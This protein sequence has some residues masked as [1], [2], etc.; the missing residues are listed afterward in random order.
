METAA[1]PSQYK[2]A[3]VTAM[4]SGL[5]GAPLKCRTL[6]RALEL[7]ESDKTNPAM[8]AGRVYT[9]PEMIPTQHYFR[10]IGSV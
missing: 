9:W 4:Q 7:L 5:I 3:Y 8:F 2:Y 6:E 1:Y 10:V